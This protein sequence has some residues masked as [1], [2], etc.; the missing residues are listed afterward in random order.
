ML[1]NKWLPR[2]EA[3]ILLLGRLHFKRET[4]QNIYVHS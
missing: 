1:N 2:N 3:A 4:L